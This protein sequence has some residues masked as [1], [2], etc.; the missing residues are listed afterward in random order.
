VE[1]MFADPVTEKPRLNTT[2][3]WEIYNFTADAHPIHLHQ[4]QF[5]V[6]NRQ[7][8]VTDV[9]GITVAPATLAGP[10]VPRESWE[11]GTKDTVISYPG[12]VTRLKARFDIPGLYVWHCHILDHEDNEMM[13]PIQVVP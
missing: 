9:D 4:V 3:L 7:P 11:R 6:V 5:E 2:E 13:R 1:K 8:L 10:P 12:M